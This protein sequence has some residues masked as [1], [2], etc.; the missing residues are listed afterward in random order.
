GGW[1]A[2]YGIGLGFITGFALGGLLFW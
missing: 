1:G 2:A